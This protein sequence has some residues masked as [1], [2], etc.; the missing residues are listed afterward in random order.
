MVAKPILTEWYPHVDAY[1]LVHACGEACGC[2]RSSDD[3]RPEP[4]RWGVRWQGQWGAP[5]SRLWPRK[6]ARGAPVPP[7]VF[8]QLTAGSC[9]RLCTLVHACARLYTLVHTYTRLCMLVHA[10]ARLY[11]LVHACTRLYTLVY[12]YTHLYTLVHAYTHLYTFVHACAC[13]YTLVHACTR[14]Y[15]L[16]HTYTHLYTLVHAY[17]H[18]YTLV[19]AYTHLYTLIHTCIHLYTLIHTCIHL[20]T[21]IHGCVSVRRGGPR[22]ACTLPE[23]LAAK[24]PVQECRYPLLYWPLGHSAHVNMCS[25]RWT[26][27]SPLFTHLSGAPS[28]AAGSVGR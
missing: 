1:T 24:I 12:T 11:T 17:T 10:C 8:F 18:L 3:C 5:C 4:Q 28:P 27:A 23:A 2:V 19:H 14:L 15:T 20:Y 16:V 6:Q 7:K 26:P 9:T 21:L 22:N 25:A 13:L